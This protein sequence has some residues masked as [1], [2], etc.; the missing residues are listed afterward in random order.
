MLNQIGGM[1]K[2]GLFQVKL[3]SVHSIDAAVDTL[4]AN[5]AT[6]FSSIVISKLAVAKAVKVANAIEFFIE[7][8]RLNRE[9]VS[10]LKGFARTAAEKL[11]KRIDNAIA[12]TFSGNDYSAAINLYEELTGKSVKARKTKK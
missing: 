9:K 4:I 6:G 5:G 3:D 8:S 10:K 11:L 7:H 2:G 12:D 1:P